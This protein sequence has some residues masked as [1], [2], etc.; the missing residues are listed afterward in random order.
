[1]K[2]MKKI[3]F[4]FVFA[5][6]VSCQLSVREQIKN[7]SPYWISPDGNAMIY[8]SHYKENDTY[9]ISLSTWITNNSMEGGAGIFDIKSNKLDTLKVRWISNYN[10][11]ISFPRTANISRQLSETYFAGRKIQLQYN[12]Y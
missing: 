8:Q 1:M 4:L 3:L 2:F 12:A 5:N 9:F 11:I 6:I 7:N 10:A